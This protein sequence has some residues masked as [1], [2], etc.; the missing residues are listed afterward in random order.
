MACNARSGTH[1]CEVAVLR[2]WDSLD[3]EPYFSALPLV[4]AVTRCKEL[5]ARTR[6][7]AGEAPSEQLSACPGIE[8]LPVDRGWR[9][10]LHC[11]V[12]HDAGWSRCERSNRECEYYRRVAER[13][14]RE[15]SRCA[16]AERA[17]AIVHRGDPVDPQ[18]SLSECER[19]RGQLR[20]SGRITE[21]SLCRE[22][23]YAELVRGRRRFIPSPTTR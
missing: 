6:R 3:I 21:A 5:D 1:E 19:V 18:P 11:Y 16:P 12:S 10:G 9:A 22:M 17:W 13:G 23:G 7:C 8:Q 4:D 15:V 20:A 2:Y 14:Q